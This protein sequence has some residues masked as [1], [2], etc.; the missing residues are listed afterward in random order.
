MIWLLA[1]KLEAGALKHRGC[2]FLTGIALAQGSVLPRCCSQC[3]GLDPAQLRLPAQ[4]ESTHRKHLQGE[5]CYQH[6][7]KLRSCVVV[8]FS[9]II[10]VNGRSF[11]SWKLDQFSPI[12]C[13]QWQQRAAWSPWW[14]HLLLAPLPMVQVHNP[15][16]LLFLPLGE[17]AFAGSTFPSLRV[18]WKVFQHGNPS[19]LHIQLK[20][21]QQS[22]F[23][24]CA[25]DAVCREPEHL[26]DHYPVPPNLPPKHEAV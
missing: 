17:I 26:W 7:A 25:L 11:G 2:C 24:P 16:L 3:H 18:A 22:C 10:Y 12:G 5:I 13:Q 1:W 14:G 6:R 23:S 19:M 15:E 20:C 4:L 9:L 21:Q 8:S